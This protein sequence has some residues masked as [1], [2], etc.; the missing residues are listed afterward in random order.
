M[1]AKINL[2]NIKSYLVGNF[3]YACY[4]NSWS[5]LIRKHILEQIKWRIEIMN[6]VC[7]EQ[8]S[9]ELCGCSTTALQMANK[10]CDKPCYPTM[11][12]TFS[13]KLFKK[14]SLYMDKNLDV[15]WKMY[16]NTPFIVFSNNKNIKETL[17]L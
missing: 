15:V 5:V 1:K 17:K 7:Y 3:R 9:C 6:P 13:W 12:N 14:G 2:L 10:A 16:D 4:D 8:G 11:M